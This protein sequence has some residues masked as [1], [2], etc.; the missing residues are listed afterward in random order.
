ML[1][2]MA[3]VVC[4]VVVSARRW[5]SYYFTQ[6]FTTAMAE[7]IDATPEDGDDYYTFL[8]IPRN[9]RSEEIGA[10]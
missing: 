6:Y 10:I 4:R 1:R 2:W 7:E 3:V 8:N 5:I 9:V